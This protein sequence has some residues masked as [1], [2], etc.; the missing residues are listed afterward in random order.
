M[1]LG[2]EARGGAADLWED[3]LEGL[4]S[5]VDAFIWFLELRM[6]SE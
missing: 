2:E 5:V 1:I 4:D 6:K 3:T